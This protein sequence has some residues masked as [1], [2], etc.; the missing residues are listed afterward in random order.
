VR[1]WSAAGA[2][3]DS[4]F[5]LLLDA[6]GTTGFHDVGAY[7]WANDT[8]SASYTPSAGYSYNS[9]LFACDSGSNS[10]GK[11]STGRFFMRH[12]LV[13]ATEST[14]H[15][16]A[17]NWPGAA[18]YCKIEGWIPWGSGGVEVRTRCFDASGAPNDSQY[19]ESYYT[20]Q[21]QG[22]C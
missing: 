2:L 11:L 5:S 9:G 14:V 4:T 20:V 15:V 22:P 17:R 12:T 16:T 10:A 3:T 13:G 6:A 21:V 8:A 19:A 7:A 1:C 18:D